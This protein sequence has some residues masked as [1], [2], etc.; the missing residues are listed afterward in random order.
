MK[1]G[2]SITRYHQ[3]CFAPRQDAVP[4]SIDSDEHKLDKENFNWFEVRSLTLSWASILGAVEKVG[5]KA[6]QW[7]SYNRPRSDLTEIFPRE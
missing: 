3:V 7:I 5:N 6:L 2:C 4:M 1:K